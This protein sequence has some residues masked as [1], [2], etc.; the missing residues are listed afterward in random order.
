METFCQKN[1]IIMKHGAPTTPTTQGL[2][3]RSKRSCKKVLHTLIVSTTRN[4]LKW[5]SSLSNISY[6]R[7]ITIFTRQS[8]Q[9]PTK[10]C[11]ALNPTEKYHGTK[12]QRRFLKTAHNNLRN[13]TPAKS[14]KV[15][16]MNRHLM[17]NTKEDDKKI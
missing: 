17:R 5:C 3:E 13:L 8:I 14:F 2:T 12:T 15:N 11:L 10:L 9:R 4:N 16:I 6:T 1:G 7:N